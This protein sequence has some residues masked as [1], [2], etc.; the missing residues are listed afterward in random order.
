MNIAEGASRTTNKER[1]RFYEVARG[2]LVETDTALT[3]CVR[4]KY[5]KVEELSK[6][7][8]L[9]NHEFSMLSKMIST[10]S[11]QSSS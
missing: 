3:V 7:L 10:L 11:K 5:L 4:L 6:L 2:S 1:K 8:N 9:M